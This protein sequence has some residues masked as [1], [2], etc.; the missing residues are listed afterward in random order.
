MKPTYSGIFKA[1]HV[2]GWINHDIVESLC[3][4]LFMSLSY[5]IHLGHGQSFCP[6]WESNSG[7]SDRESSYLPLDQSANS[8]S[9]V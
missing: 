1:R 8:L 7:P 4:E 3:S 2:I 5:Y 9:K 6:T